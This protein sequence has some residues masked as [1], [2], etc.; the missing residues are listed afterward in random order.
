MA[1]RRRS[2]FVYPMTSDAELS[3]VFA[4]AFVFQMR[5]R[6]DASMNRFYR[7]CDVATLGYRFVRFPFE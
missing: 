2:S 6:G 4:Q 7:A 1:N 5:R 3:A